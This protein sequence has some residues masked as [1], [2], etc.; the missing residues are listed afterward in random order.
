VRKN[1][2]KVVY[3]ARDRSN[4]YLCATERWEE[5]AERGTVVRVGV[6]R[7]E[8]VIEVTSAAKVVKDSGVKR[9]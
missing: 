7:L 5:H 2:P 1:P 4:E 8:R 3:V 6:Y 9:P